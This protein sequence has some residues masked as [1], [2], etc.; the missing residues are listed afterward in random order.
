[1]SPSFSQFSFQILGYYGYSEFATGPFHE[2]DSGE[3]D[4]LEYHQV[5]FRLTHLGL[6]PVLLAQLLIW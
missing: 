2:N 3:W 4:S 1:V 6:N 5:A